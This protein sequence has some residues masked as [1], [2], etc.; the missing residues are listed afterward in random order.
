MAVLSTMKILLHVS[1]SINYLARS[2]EKLSAS[3]YF[4]IIEMVSFLHLPGSTSAS[5]KLLNAAVSLLSALLN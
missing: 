4:D 2:S 3:L 1:T 5:F